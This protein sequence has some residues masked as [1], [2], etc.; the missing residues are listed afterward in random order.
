MTNRRP[1]H[2][3]LTAPTGCNAQ[4]S[5]IQLAD[6][7][8]GSSALWVQVAVEGE[9]L[10]YT[11]PDGTQGFKFTRAIFQEVVDNVKG[12]PSFDGK[13]G[14]IPWDF[15]HASA[16]SATEGMRPMTG[17][18]TTGWSSD[19]EIRE[20]DGLSQLWMLTEFSEPARGYVKAGQYKWASVVLNFSTI[21]KVT[22]KPIG[23]LVS[24]I[25]LTNRPFIEGMEQ[26]VAASEDNSGAPAPG[27]PALAEENRM[28]FLKVLAGM[29]SV[30][31]TQEAV[32]AQIKGLIT[33]QEQ[34][35][36]LFSMPANRATVTAVLQEVTDARAG[37]VTLGTLVGA[38]G[39]KDGG[40]AA[41]KI[42]DLMTASVKLGELEPKMKVLLE[43]QT[44]IE[45][46]EIKAD[47]DRAIASNAAF[48]EAMRPMFTLSRTNDKDAFLT[49]YPADA[50]PAA[51]AA[52][53]MTAAELAVLQANVAATP[54]GTQLA[55]QS[56]GAPVVADPMARLSVGTS[57]QVTLAPPVGAPGPTVVPA[58]TGMLGGQA[59]NLSLFPGANDTQRM[60]AYL[61]Q[62]R[63]GFKDQK[64]D[65]QFESACLAIKQMKGAAA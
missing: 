48:N 7:V 65:D 22:G 12:H 50:T 11:L 56:G 27:Q 15:D 21:D 16:S 13:V 36:T 28:D 61:S 24:S 26:L 60:V 14:I 2:V 5:I 38:L 63:S 23:A 25:A 8:E 51:P 40:E 55:V 44:A 46:S 30:G 62:T 4:R 17:S 20:S 9:F 31:E 53:A 54:T 10:G 3:M 39:A 59:V 34:L 43:A 42:A 35:V 47:V 45:G 18:P 41:T 33:L 32:T 6:H 37:A 58:A 64:W 52:P 29:L 49:Q 57:G 1:M 19:A